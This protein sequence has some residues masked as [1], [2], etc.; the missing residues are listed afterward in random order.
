T[1]DRPCTDVLRPSGIPHQ[2]HAR[3]SVCAGFHCHFGLCCISDVE[4]HDLRIHV[5]GTVHLWSHCMPQLCV[6]LVLDPPVYHRYPLG[7]HSKF[8]YVHRSSCAH[9][10]SN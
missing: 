5:V 7:L 1:R 9:V 4:N 6:R 3:H 8:L 2:Q 10:I